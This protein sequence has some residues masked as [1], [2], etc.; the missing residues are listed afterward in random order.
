MA[1]RIEYSVGD[2]LC[3]KTGVTFLEELPPREKIYNGYVHR[4]RKIKALCPCGRAFEKELSDIK[5]GS[6][7]QECGKETHKRAMTK[8]FEGSVIN[9][10][11][12]ILVKR[13]RPQDKSYYCEFKCGSCDKTFYQVLSDMIKGYG[14]CHEC[15]VEITQSNR[16]KYRVGDIITSV[17]GYQFYFEKELPAS[18]HMRR[19]VFYEVNQAGEQIGER[20]SAV[21]YNVICGT[22]FGASSK[23]NKRFLDCLQQLSY[24]FC[25]EVTFPDLLSDKGFPLRYDFGV[26]YNDQIILFEL[27][28]EQH[29]KRIDYF[30]GEEGYQ[31][32]QYFD[33]LKNQYAQDHG[34]SLVRIP[35]TEFSSIT[36]ELIKKIVEGGE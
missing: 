27:D 10:R 11:G 18:S 4:F 29:F 30:G 21:V 17:D 9:D 23:G 22:A 7:C 16:Q 32:R 35:Y 14:I 20:F 28:G 1:K 5:R 2:I 26:Y 24:I 12:T 34:Y 15:V 33:E 31:Q 36:P 25:T 6:L 3:E 8:Y 19:G 13:I